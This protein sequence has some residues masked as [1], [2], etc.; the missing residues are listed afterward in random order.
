VSEI[1]R[2]VFDHR[3][4]ITV[5]WMEKACSITASF[6]DPLEA[7]PVRV[8]AS[9]KSLPVRTEDPP[10]PQEFTAVCPEP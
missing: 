9:P 2:M 8:S 4:S 3:Y 7:V 6:Q 5:G 10:N 1:A